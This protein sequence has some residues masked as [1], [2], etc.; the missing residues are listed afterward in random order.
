MENVSFVNKVNESGKSLYEIAKKAHVPYTTVNRL[1]HGK[2]D[3]NNVQSKA[4]FCI[5]CA[6]DC[7]MTDLMN[8]FD[9]LPCVSDDIDGIPYSWTTED[10]KSVLHFNLG[11]DHVDHSMIE[12]FGKPQNR[13]L[14]H[15]AAKM[16]IENAAQ[17]KKQ[18]QIM[19]AMYKKGK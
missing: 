14:Y 2:L 18:H 8:R 11:K 12:M 15:L 5:A 4:L 17:Q 6:L 3:I 16:L 1:Y 10:Q 19:S 7:D 9:Y 13:Y